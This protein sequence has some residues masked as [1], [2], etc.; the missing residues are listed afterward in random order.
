MATVTQILE[1]GR[2]A[3]DVDQVRRDFPALALTVHDRPLVYLDNA[4]TAQKPRS[5]LDAESKFY[6]DSYANVHRGVHALSLKAT[7]WIGRS[8]DGDVTLESVMRVGWERGGGA[9]AGSCGVSLG[10]VREPSCGAGGGG[11]WSRKNAGTAVVCV[12]VVAGMVGGG[13]D[14]VNQVLA[15]PAGHVDLCQRHGAFPPLGTDARSPLGRRERT[16]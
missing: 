14:F 8:S 4:A 1:T 16:G 13:Q 5:V 12:A 11:W 10:S 2:P 15:D 6:R 7:T 9:V 3:L